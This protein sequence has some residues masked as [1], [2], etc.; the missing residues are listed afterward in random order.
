M[1]CA[2][3]VDADFVQA[4]I[5]AVTESDRWT[6]VEDEL[7][8]MLNGVAAANLVRRHRIGHTA[9]QTYNICRQSA[10]QKK[11]HPSCRTCKE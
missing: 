9:L 5:N 11:T 7:R 2:A 1:R 6:G 3:Q 4:S 8:A 10:R